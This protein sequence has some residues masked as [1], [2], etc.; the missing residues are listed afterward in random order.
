MGSDSSDGRPPE[1]SKVVISE[2]LD[3]RMPGR[4]SLV[5]LS[6]L[7]VIELLASGLRTSKASRPIE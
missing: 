2:L 6:L 1:S 7:L 4:G 5:A 3:S